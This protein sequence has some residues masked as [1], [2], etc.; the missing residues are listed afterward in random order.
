M[1]WTADAATISAPRG[2]AVR[3]LM[4]GIDDYVAANKLHGAVADARDLNAALLGAGVPQS[5]LRLVLERDATRS[6]VL[7]E[8]TALA[9]SAQPGDLVI[10]AFAGHGMRVKEMYPDSKPD[11]L[12]EAYV[13]VQFTPN[14]KGAG[15]HDFIPGP[16]IKHWIAALDAR[17]IDVL[18][19]ADTCH[20][21]GLTRKP[22]RPDLV[23]TYREI[24]TSAYAQA[25][26]SIYSSRADA[27]RPPASFPHLTFVAAVDPSRKVPEVPIEIA[28]RVVQRGALSYGV[29]R[30]IEGAVRPNG[31]GVV[32]RR[33][34][35]EYLRQEVTHYSDAQVIY[36]TPEQE[37]RLDTPVFRVM[38]EA[39]E[40]PAPQKP[41]ADVDPLRV[42]VEGG[43]ARALAGIEM[44]VHPFRV[45]TGKETADI[46]WNAATREA[47]FDGD[48]GA[49]DVTARGVPD[50]VDRVWIARRLARLA[51]DRVQT[52]RV[53][54]DHN[55]HH[56]GEV[57][58]LEADGVAGKYLIAFNA[59][60]DGVVQVLFPA[61]GENALAG[62]DGWRIGGIK[63]SDH[64][65]SDLVVLVVSPTRLTD[66][67]KSLAS[68]D[69][70]S[71]AGLIPAMLQPYLDPARRVRLGITPVVTAP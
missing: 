16:E 42:M 46:T 58:S 19:I 31:Q 47:H 5:N 53:L 65:G 33:T 56:K 21:G 64:F 51:D 14:L 6:R 52:F 69:Q 15:E 62:G 7:A 23:G 12:D 4:V 13:L 1:P 45:V 10:L 29:A 55:L 35:F 9:G 24:D 22:V 30:A 67:E 17:G 32:T 28:G 39:A 3:A 2:G 61:P 38:G 66:L 37:D 27:A 34:L 40:K 50:V 57:L 44:H 54:P 43:D 36:S 60:G 59:T 48:L 26:A 18:F 11:H 25:E 20:G 63:V 49:R 71:N 41:S 70:T 8:M 68:I